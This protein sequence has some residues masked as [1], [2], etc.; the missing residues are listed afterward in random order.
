MRTKGIH[1][2][3]RKITSARSFGKCLSVDII[4]MFVC[5]YFHFSYKIPTGSKIFTA[6]TIDPASTKSAGIELS[7]PSQRCLSTA[8]ARSFVLII[9]GMCRI[10]RSLCLSKRNFAKY[11]P[12]CPHMPVIN[13]A[14][15]ISNVPFGGDA[16][17]V[18]RD[19]SINLCSPF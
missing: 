17:S 14:F 1:K 12:S 7:S 11:A 2:R 16:Q 8:I 5:M 9:C 10:L 15:V 18:M 6:S 3:V 13:A 4:C 19:A